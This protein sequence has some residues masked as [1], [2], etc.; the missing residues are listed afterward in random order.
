ME[1]EE[2]EEEE[3]EIYVTKLMKESIIECQ[4]MTSNMTPKVTTM[5]FCYFKYSLVLSQ[6]EG[7]TGRKIRSA[8][9]D[10][11]DY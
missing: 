11:R 2:E 5:D 4:T 7:K 1:E 8:V 6:S 9:S 3:E 10:D